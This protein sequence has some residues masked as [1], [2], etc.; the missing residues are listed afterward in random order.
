MYEI[1][2]SLI[3]NSRGLVL[4]EYK[5]FVEILIGEISDLYIR[6]QF[7]LFHGGDWRGKTKT[8]KLVRRLL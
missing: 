6:R 3:E 1:I 5:E 8:E 2:L 7:Q 4:W